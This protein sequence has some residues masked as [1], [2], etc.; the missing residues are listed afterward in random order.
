MLL[1]DP[2]GVVEP[3]PASTGAR[4]EGIDEA[5]G[6]EVVYVN[7]VRGEIAHHVYCVTSDAIGIQEETVDRVVR[8][9]R[10]KQWVIPIFYGTED[11]TIVVR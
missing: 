7:N 11:R 3:I 2:L 5:L 8:L 4:V 6:F 10:E 9:K 1:E